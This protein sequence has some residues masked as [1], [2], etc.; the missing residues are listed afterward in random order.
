[1][2][3]QGDVTRLLRAYRGGDREAFDRLFPLVYDELK[4]IARRNLRGGGRDHTL[5]ATGVVHEAYL[6]LAD[7]SRVSIEDRAHF[8]AVAAM[9]MRQVV[10]SY[11]RRKSAA[12]RGS[13]GPAV[14]LDDVDVAVERDASRVL[15]VDRALVRLAERD[16]RLA[17]VFELRFFGGLSEEE[18][19]AALETSARTVQRDW[20]RSKAWLREELEHGGDS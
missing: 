17:R 10:V 20:Q 11:A 12:K 2:A 9:A 8:F 5:G 19:A 16:E 7:A 6:K 3:E 4:R 13:G 15:D 14:P 1:M 18:T